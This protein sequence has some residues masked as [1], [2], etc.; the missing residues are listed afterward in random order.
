MQQKQAEMQ[1]KDS[2]NMRDNETSILIA[3][4][5]KYAN[6]ETSEDIEFSEEAKA[7][8]S[9]KIRQFDEKLAFDNKKLKIESRL[10]E[11]QINKNIQRILFIF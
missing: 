8:L 6:E 5:S 4:M 1:L 10:K 7:N 11:K 3:Q 2:M 9:E